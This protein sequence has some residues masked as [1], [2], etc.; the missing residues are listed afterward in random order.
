MPIYEEWDTN[1][2]MLRRVV[3]DDD[4]NVVDEWPDVTD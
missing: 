4:G 1:G 3:T 2:T